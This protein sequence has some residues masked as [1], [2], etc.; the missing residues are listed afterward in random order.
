VYLLG[1]RPLVS[2]KMEVFNEICIYLC[3]YNVMLFLLDVDTQT[4]IVLGWSLN[5]GASFN[6]LS[7]IGGIVVSMLL[8]LLKKRNSLKRRKNS[9]LFRVLKRRKEIL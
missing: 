7:N 5:A 3:T 9:V 6:I 4:S 2:F 1:S 8:L